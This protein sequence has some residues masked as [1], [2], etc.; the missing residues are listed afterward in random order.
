MKTKSK[1]LVQPLLE[2]FSPIFYVSKVLGFFPADFGAYK[3]KKKLEFNIWGSAIVS[4]VAIFISALLFYMIGFIL[5]E[6]ELIKSQS[7]S[8]YI[9]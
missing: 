3:N 1:P 4:M 2:D 9:L 5:G 6:N 8:K 7:K